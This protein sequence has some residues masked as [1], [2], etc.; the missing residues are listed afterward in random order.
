MSTSRSLF[1]LILALALPLSAADIRVSAAASLTDA[2]RELGPLYE[3]STGNRLIFNFG[4]SSTLA[5]QIE[6]GSSAD[7]FI[8]ADEAKMDRLQQRG[9]IST[10]TRVR[11]LSNTLVVVVRKESKLA[12]REPRDLTKVR[13]LALAEPE[14]VPAGIYARQWLRKIGLWDRVASKVIPTDNVRGA[15][16]ALEI[17]AADA[18]IV[19]ATD[20]RI[21]KKA[22]VAIAVDAAAGPAISYVVAAMSEAA[23]PPLAR[24]VVA[25][26]QTRRALE[27]FARHGFIVRQR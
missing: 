19:Y 6:L 2:L 22:R 5:R 14:S 23:N 20:A 18:A 27:V 13:R 3:R 21:A 8:S 25:W 9:L 4:A 7:V 16:T 26:L 17:E 1:A 11:L 10:P 12:I 15:L 24:E